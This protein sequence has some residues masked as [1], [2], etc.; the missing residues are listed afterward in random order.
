MGIGVG[1]GVSCGGSGVIGSGGLLHE[2]AN[3]R[4]RIPTSLDHFIESASTKFIQSFQAKIQAID[5]GS[6]TLFLFRLKPRG[7][8]IETSPIAW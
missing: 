7:G 8:N 3:A 2:Q 6:L 1:V 5:C 4:M